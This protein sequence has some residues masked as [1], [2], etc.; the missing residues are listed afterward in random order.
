MLVK[1]LQCLRDC[2]TVLDVCGGTGRIARHLVN[3]GYKVKV[4]DSSEDMLRIARRKGLDVEIQDARHLDERPA[5]YDAVICLGNSLGGIPSKAGRNQAIREMARV[6]RK[7]VIIDCANRLCDL[8]VVW[9]PMYVRHWAGCYRPGLQL[10]KDVCSGRN[11]G[12]I[13]FHDRELD[14]VLYHYVYSSL[15]L[16]EEME[17]AGLRVHA[18][19][20]ILARRV[21]LVGDKRREP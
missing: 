15:E 3:Q 19:N 13:V 16:K 5:S 11:L 18:V 1:A 8:A 2:T 17:R 20:S 21:A 9:L 7:R 14:A 12:E 6:S 10:R 4:V